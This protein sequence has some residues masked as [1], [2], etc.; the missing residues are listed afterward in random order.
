MRKSYVLFTFLISS[1]ILSGCKKQVCDYCGKEKYC[2]KYDI[3]GTSRYICDD[4]INNPNSASNNVLSGYM[5]EPLD[6]ALLGKQDSAS[7]DSA[8]ENTDNP[9][10]DGSL[11]DSSNQDLTASDNNSE[12]PQVTSEYETYSKNDIVNSFSALLSEYNIEPEAS[13]DDKNIY[14]VKDNNGSTIIKF[15]FSKSDSGLLTLTV[16]RYTA[17][18]GS[19][20]VSSCICAS[21]AFLGTADYDGTGYTIYNSAVAHG[22][23]TYDNCRF[24]YLENSDSGNS[25]DTPYASYEISYK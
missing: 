8:S 3:V 12:V 21:L 17:D 10:A 2:T 19:D 7:E 4:C 5:A 6:P 14:E 20:Y 13:E 16:D 18:C 22:N 25:S 24:Y 1:I 9:E 23:Y 15:T 11:A